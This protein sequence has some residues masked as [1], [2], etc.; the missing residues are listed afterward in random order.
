MSDTPKIEKQIPIPSRSKWGDVVARMEVG[1]SV[2]VS[3][4]E[5]SSLRAQARLHGHQ[6]T[7]RTIKPN[8][9]RVWRTA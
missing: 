9:V 8:R 3:M 1:D 6:V 5:A 2:L 7:S 4:T